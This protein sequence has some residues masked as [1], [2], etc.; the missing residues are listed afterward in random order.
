MELVC[1]GSLCANN[2]RIC[3]AA[4]VLLYFE[5]DHRR[6]Q[7]QTLHPF[8]SSISPPPVLL[9]RFALVLFAF[10]CVC[11]GSFLS[12]SLSLSVSFPFMAVLPGYPR[13]LLSLQQFSIECQ[14][15][16]SRLDG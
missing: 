5:E 15:A 12:F 7:E 6:S 16:G 4:V 2:L 1:S 11:L 10:L 9:L 3:V 13:P 8:V 14:V